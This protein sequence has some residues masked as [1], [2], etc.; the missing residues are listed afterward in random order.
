MKTVLIIDDS[1]TSR[2]LFKAHM[3]KDGIITVLEANDGE[4]ALKVVAAS[5]PDMIFLDYNMP[6]RNGLD[7]AADLIAM[8]Y[9]GRLALLTAN[10]QASLV[11][12][13][14][15]LGV[16]LVIEKPITKEKILGALK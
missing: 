16:E 2:L 3:P 1:A 7:V 10:T 13:A 12:E 5:N 14:K 11:A 9:Q 4:S 8:G 15:G 6:N